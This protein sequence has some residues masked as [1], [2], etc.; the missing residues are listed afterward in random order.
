MAA[1]KLKPRKAELRP[2]HSVRHDETGMTE[3]ADTETDTEERRRTE[4]VLS[5][6][7]SC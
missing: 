4:K 7:K 5:V 2:L 6:A 3:P 1:I